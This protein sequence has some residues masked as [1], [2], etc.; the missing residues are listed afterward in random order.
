M[1]CSC[2][3]YWCNRASWG[4]HNVWGKNER[5]CWHSKID[6]EHSQ[7]WFDPW[8]FDHVSSG[9]L[10]F[11]LIPPL[12]KNTVDHVNGQI[13]ASITWWLLNICVHIGWELFENSPLILWFFRFVKEDGDYSGGDSVVNSISDS[14]IAC[15]VGWWIAYVLW[16]TVN[17]WWI[18]IIPF[19]ILQIISTIF[20]VGFVLKLYHYGKAG[21]FLIRQCCCQIPFPEDG[22]AFARDEDTK[23]ENETNNTKET[24]QDLEIAGKP[25]PLQIQILLQLCE[26]LICIV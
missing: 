13:G 26:R 2:S 11:I 19:V 23:T 15:S 16:V 5:K 6:H 25:T 4:W 18:F 22:L 9:I 21:F 20:G 14:V 1:D 24:D 7:H 10:Q 17:R 8:T 3:G 12:W